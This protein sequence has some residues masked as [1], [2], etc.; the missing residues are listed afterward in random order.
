VT[1]T[2]HCVPSSGNRISGLR[3]TRQAFGWISHL[4]P[5]ARPLRPVLRVDEFAAEACLELLVALAVEFTLA[6]LNLH[7]EPPQVFRVLVVL[8]RHCVTER[9]AEE[10]QRIPLHHKKRRAM[11]EVPDLEA[12]SPSRLWPFSSCTFWSDRVAAVKDRSAVVT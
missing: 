10:F 6:A 7:N 2:Y 11:S 3:T 12:E 5:R 8:Q 9:N 4:A 1:G